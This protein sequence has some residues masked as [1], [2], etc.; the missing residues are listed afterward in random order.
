MVDLS[1]TLGDLVLL[2][3]ASNLSASLDICSCGLGLYQ[4][5]LFL[6]CYVMD[7]Q[8]KLDKG[9]DSIVSLLLLPVENVFF[10]E[11]ESIP[12]YVLA[13]TQ[14]IALAN[15]FKGV[16]LVVAETQVVHPEVD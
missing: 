2:G 14:P 7:L 16:Q 12:L 6:C 5:D 10:L 3:R 8:C 15:V 1:V 4:S 9:V 11:S 13:I